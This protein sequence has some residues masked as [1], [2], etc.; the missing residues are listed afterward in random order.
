M[1]SKTALFIALFTFKRHIL[2]VWNYR[3]MFIHWERIRCSN[4]AF[5]MVGRMARLLSPER[6]WWIF[7]FGSSIVHPPCPLFSPLCRPMSRC[8]VLPGLPI[9]CRQQGTVR[10]ARWK[11]FRH[12]IIF[13]KCPSYLS[14]R[15]IMGNFATEQPRT[16][17]RVPIL[18][19]RF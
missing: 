2:A 6:I 15:I 18:K 19:I 8:M 13:K 1:D 17:P 11:F 5:L 16:P 14:C 4:H 12:E 9:R 10:T 3:V 7:R